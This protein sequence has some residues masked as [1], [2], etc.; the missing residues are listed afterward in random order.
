M[1]GNDADE[2]QVTFDQ[3]RGERDDERDAHEQL[4]RSITQAGGQQRAARSRRPR[5][6]CR[7]RRGGRR[8]DGRRAAAP[9]LSVRGCRR[10]RS[11]RSAARAPACAPAIA[12]A[13]SA[14]HRVSPDADGRRE[15]RSEDRRGQ[16]ELQQCVAR[17]PGRPRG[18]A[19]DAGAGGDAGEAEQHGQP[20]DP[21]RCPAVRSHSRRGIHRR[22]A[23]EGREQQHLATEPRAPPHP[24]RTI[25]MRRPSKVQRRRRERQPADQRATRAP[26]AKVRRRHRATAAARWSRTRRPRAA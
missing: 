24:K 13:A 21:R 2:E 10:R 7:E 23:G 20:A 25:R 3:F 4:P 9:S 26:R 12:A 22:D 19:I 8:S 16:V 15:Q 1:F 6:E 17:V 14:S 18:H 5:A 11:G